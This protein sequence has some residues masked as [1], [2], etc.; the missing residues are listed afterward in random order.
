MDVLD[1]CNILAEYAREN[2][3]LFVDL[4]DIGF[5]LATLVANGAAMPTQRGMFYLQETWTAL[6]AVLDVDPSSVYS[7]L[8]EMQGDS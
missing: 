7:S 4:N 8:Y 3:N 1:I 2:K 6:C 5:P